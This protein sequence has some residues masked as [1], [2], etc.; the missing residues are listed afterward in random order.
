[1]DINVEENFFDYVKNNPDRKIVVYGMGNEARK[2]YKDIGRI[3]YF[4][5]QRAKRIEPIKNIP[6]LL[7]EELE[8]IHE[9]MVILICVRKKDIADQ[10]C[11]ELNKLQIDAEIFHYFRNPAV[12]CLSPYSELLSLA[13]VIKDKIM[14]KGC[15]SIIDIGGDGKNYISLAGGF[16]SQCLEYH[17]ENICLLENKGD[18]LKHMNKEVIERLGRADVCLLEDLSHCISPDSDLLREITGSGVEYIF[19]KKYIPRTMI[20][21]QKL[22]RSMYNLGY[23]ICLDLSWSGKPA[24]ARNGHECDDKSAYRRLLYQTRESRI[25]A[26]W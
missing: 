2:N 8:E 6:C 1:M 10:I 4:C 24:R 14:E 5:D 9:R 17:M 21:H 7:P 13:A 23:D 18:R 19:I 20:E 11:M 25:H 15:C 12:S 3:D 26:N 16:G 22:N